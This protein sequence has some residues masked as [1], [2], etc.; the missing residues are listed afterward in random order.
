MFPSGNGFND[1]NM[2]KITTKRKKFNE[3][4]IDETQIKL[5]SESIWLWVAMQPESKEITVIDISKERNMF[6]AQSDFYLI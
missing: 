3:F 2:K 5:G 1:I 6:V 4:I